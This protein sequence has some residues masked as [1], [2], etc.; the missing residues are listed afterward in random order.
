MDTL[1]YDCYALIFNCLDFKSLANLLNCNNKYIYYNLINYI[2]Q[3]NKYKDVM[4]YDEYRFSIYYSKFYLKIR[5][6]TLNIIRLGC[7][8]NVLKWLFSQQGILDEFWF[9]SAAKSGNLENMKWLKRM[10]CSINESTFKTIIKT[11]IIENIQW[12]YDNCNPR[13]DNSYFN[14]A[15][16][17]GNIQLMKYLKG[18][19]LSFDQFTFYNAVFPISNCIILTPNSIPFKKLKKVYSKKGYTESRIEIMEWLKSNNCSW[20]ILTYDLIS[21]Y[22]MPLEY[23]TQIYKWMYD[24]D[25]PQY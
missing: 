8:I 14:I 5:P 20:G 17:K 6:D 22:E 25:C 2:K 3:T 19:G 4:R 15:V 1:Y 9:S 11:E 10:D 7:N 12:F 18:L 16:K 24:N 13:N 23:F 21:I